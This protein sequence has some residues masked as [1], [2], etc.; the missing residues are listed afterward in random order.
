MMLW[1]GGACQTCLAQEAPKP[2]INGRSWMGMRKAHTAICCF[3]ALFLHLPLAT[4]GHRILAF[5][6]HQ[7]GSWLNQLPPQV[8]S[9]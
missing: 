9:C 7:Y 6:L 4:A 2:L 8:G 5:D 3:L 1:K